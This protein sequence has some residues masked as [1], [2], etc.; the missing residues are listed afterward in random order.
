MRQCL[1]VRRHP[2]YQNGYIGDSTST[3]KV[4]GPFDT[5]AAHEYADEMNSRDT[6]FWYAVAYIDKDGKEVAL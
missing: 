4:F 2:V 6:G 1:K 5:E 3:A